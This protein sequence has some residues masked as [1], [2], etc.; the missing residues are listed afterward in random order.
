MNPIKAIFWRLH[1]SEP[2]ENIIALQM[3]TDGTRFCST[4]NNYGHGYC[5]KNYID[6]PEEKFDKVVCENWQKVWHVS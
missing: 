6:V 1:P 4:C 2:T 3:L 5:S